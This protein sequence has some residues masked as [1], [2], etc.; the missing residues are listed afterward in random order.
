MEQNMDEKIKKAI[1]AATTSE[2]FAKTL[3]IELVELSEGFSHVRMAYNKSLMDNIYARAHGGA[4]FGLIDEAFETASQTGGTIAVAL[5]VSVT[6]ISSPEFECMLEAKAQKV[7]ETRKTALYQITVTDE[8]GQTVAACQALAYKT[9]RPI[10]F[11]E[12]QG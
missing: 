4:V 9:G 1:F 12:Q 10:P 6:Y 7:S 2:P 3:G 11:V 8:K 5:N